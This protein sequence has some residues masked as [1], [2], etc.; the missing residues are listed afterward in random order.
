[1]PAVVS[2]GGLFFS[3]KNYF[4]AYVFYVCRCYKCFVYKVYFVIKS[5][6]SN[7]M[8]QVKGALRVSRPLPHCPLL[9][10]LLSHDAS[11]LE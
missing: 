9:F 4:K 3:G 8:N 1:M 11:G 5:A 7:E 6:I 2:F 10:M